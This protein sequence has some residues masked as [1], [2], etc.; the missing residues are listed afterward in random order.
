MFRPII[1]NCQF[2][3]TTPE[4]VLCEGV[5]IIGDVSNFS[6]IRIV[7]IHGNRKD[8]RL[9]FNDFLKQRECDKIFTYNQNVKEFNWVSNTAYKYQ[10]KTFRSYVKTG[11]ITCLSDNN[12]EHTLKKS[13]WYSLCLQPNNSEIC[14][15][16]LEIFSYH[17]EGFVYYFKNLKD[18][19]NAFKYLTQ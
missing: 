6:R 12:K 10:F 7:D 15:G 11:Q 18:R 3:D 16:S 9:Y 4:N 14:I 19:D 1:P 5:N 17:I 8:S 13:K 2:S